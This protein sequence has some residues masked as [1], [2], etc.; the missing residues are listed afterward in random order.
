MRCRRVF[1]QQSP[2]Q[3]PR[4]VPLSHCWS[5]TPSTSG[6]LF[7]GLCA[8]TPSFWSCHIPW[9]RTWSAPWKPCFK[10]PCLGSAAEFTMGTGSV[11]TWAPQGGLG[12]MWPCSAWLRR[13]GWRIWTR[14]RTCACTPSTGPGL[15]CEPRSSST[16][17][18]MMACAR[19]SCPAHST[20]PPASTSVWLFAAPPESRPMTFPG[21]HRLATWARCTTQSNPSP[22]PRPLAAPRA[23]SR[24]VP[25][26]RPPSP[27]SCTATSG[28]CSSNSSAPS[29]P[30]LQPPP[31]LQPPLHQ[32]PS[33]LPHP[34]QRLLSSSGRPPHQFIRQMR[35]QLAA[36]SAA[37]VAK[38][39][40]SAPLCRRP[41]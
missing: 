19:P 39:A 34:P 36:A 32:P 31:L 15:P 9:T 17:S 8:H 27:R 29:D 25:S 26:P 40:K 1:T 10:T 41:L 12:A 6:S 20:T 24:W 22:S 14:S 38:A 23:S 16:Q 35:H 13:Q 28:T 37:V 7:W 2:Q 33:L 11:Q 30:P 18:V 4:E 21:S 3:A 5:G